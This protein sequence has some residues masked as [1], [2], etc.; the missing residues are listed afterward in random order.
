MLCGLYLHIHFLIHTIFWLAGRWGVGAG[1]KEGENDLI[2]FSAEVESALV[3]PLPSVLAP[4]LYGV[5]EEEV[6]GMEDIVGSFCWTQPFW[7]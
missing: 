2:A 5:M 7:C 4:S 3:F 1:E 6:E